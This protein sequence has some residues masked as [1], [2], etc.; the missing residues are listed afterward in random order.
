[1]KGMSSGSRNACFGLDHLPTRKFEQILNIVP[2]QPAG[3]WLFL[4][5]P[6]R[7]SE[8]Q[9]WTPECVVNG[10]H[11]TGLLRRGVVQI[12]QKHLRI[13][14]HIER[15]GNGV[16]PAAPSTAHT[17]PWPTC[18]ADTIPSNS[19]LHTDPGRPHPS[20]LQSTV[21]P[22]SSSRPPAPQFRGLSLR[23]QTRHTP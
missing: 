23:G 15:V 3:L 8:F 17:P 20:P 10:H 21:R 2:R 14:D 22:S 12:F 5:K 6:K 13:R 16:R 4:T 18:H 9:A 11:Q 19:A 7:T 1:M